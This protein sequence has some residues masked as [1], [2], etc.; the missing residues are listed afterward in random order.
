MKRY[1]KEGNV[2]THTY[3]YTHTHTTFLDVVLP[4]YLV[5]LLINQ[6]LQFL[7]PEAIQVARNEP[8]PPANPPSL[9]KTFDTL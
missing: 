7:Y 6:A 8:P 9:R 4:C 1:I 2:H 5:L 3:T